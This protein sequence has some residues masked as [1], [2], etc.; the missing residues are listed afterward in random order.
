MEGSVVF[1]RFLTESSKGKIVTC[2]PSQ[3]HIRMLIK[4]KHM[5]HSLG[6]AYSST[7]GVVCKLY[8]KDRS[9][10]LCIHSEIYIIE[11]KKDLGWKGL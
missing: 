7:W 8:V 11:P 2:T 3:Y 5:P 9:K 6:E 1:A 4:A 10:S